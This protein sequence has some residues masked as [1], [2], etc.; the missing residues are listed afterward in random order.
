MTDPRFDP[1]VLRAVAASRGVE[2]TDEDLE[3]VQGF[4]RSLLPALEELERL[5]PPGT[6][7]L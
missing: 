6:A 3:A 2:V 1:A 4:L 7:E 5:V